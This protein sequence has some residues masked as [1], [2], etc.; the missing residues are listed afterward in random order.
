MIMS[1]RQMAIA[2]V[3]VYDDATDK[4]I[5]TP[6]LEVVTDDGLK[7]LRRQDGF[8]LLM[9]DPKYRSGDELG[10]NIDMQG[11]FP[12]RIIITIKERLLP[13]DIVYVRLTASEDHISNDRVQLFEGHS[14]S[15]DVLKFMPTGSRASFHLLSEVK[16][17]EDVL[18]MDSP[19]VQRLEGKLLYITNNKDKE[20]TDGK[21][22]RVKGTGGNNRYV[23]EEKA[24]NDLPIGSTIIYSVTEVL[25]DEDGNYKC[26]LPKGEYRIMGSQK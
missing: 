22:I 4:M 20:L 1:I 18:A 5:M 16:A 17:G 14:G 6:E 8:Y 13:D 11:F 3:A 2:V 9:A 15:G 7:L 23:L 10:L 12:K 26:M 24:E 25:C 21:Y 19:A